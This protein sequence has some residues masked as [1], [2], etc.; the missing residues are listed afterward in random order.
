[1]RAAL[2]KKRRLL[3]WIGIIFLAW[4]LLVDHVITVTG[5][6]NWQWS[7]DRQNQMAMEEIFKKLN[8][9]QNTFKKLP[10]QLD[11]L[12]YTRLSNK[13]SLY[14]WI[15]R[16]AVSPIL[17]EIDY[18][19]RIIFSRHAQLLYFVP[20]D[21]KNWREIPRDFI[22]LAEP[23]SLKGER[24]VYRVKNMID[25]NSELLPHPE[26]IK[27][28]EFQQQIKAQNSVITIHQGKDDLRPEQPTKEMWQQ[29]LKQFEP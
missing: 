20:P 22:I 2:S 10:P 18:F 9:Y 21:L 26:K 14:D 7:S 23:Y 15:D 29:Y 19:K 24:Y 28:A 27:E 8:T 5:N 6:A 25:D 17:A 13:S 3:N 11:G 1:M 16:D 4:Y 12:Y